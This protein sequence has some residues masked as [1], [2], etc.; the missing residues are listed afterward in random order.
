VQETVVTVHASGEPSGE[1]RQR[2]GANGES[3]ERSASPRLAAVEREPTRKQR[4]S[5]EGTAPRVGESSEGR[6][7]GTRAAWNKAAK[8]RGATENDGPREGFAR[9]VIAARTVERGKNPEDGTGE[10]LATLVLRTGGSAALAVK[11][12]TR[13]S[14]VRRS[15]NPTRG[16]SR[17]HERL[18]SVPS[19]GGGGEGAR[20]AR[21]R[22]TLKRSR[23]PREALPEPSPGSQARRERPH[24]RNERRRGGA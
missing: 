21:T 23:T 22:R 11:R 13:R 7:Q 2:I 18:P 16:G 17:A 15:K 19:T 9:S 8:R 10:G 4:P 14:C 24:G 5:R 12:G 1:P 3:T 6:L 20:A